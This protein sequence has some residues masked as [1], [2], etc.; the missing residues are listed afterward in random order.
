MTRKRVKNIDSR[1]VRVQGLVGNE[2]C[3]TPRGS[4]ETPVHF[5]LSQEPT[6]LGHFRDVMLTLNKNWTIET[7]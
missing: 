5:R 7:Q 6:A 3:F 2:A 1:V 4:T